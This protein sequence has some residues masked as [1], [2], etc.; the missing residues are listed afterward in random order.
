M[1]RQ[2]NAVDYALTLLRRGRLRLPELC[3]VMARFGASG[4]TDRS[5]VDAID[6]QVLAVLASREARSEFAGTPAEFADE[7][8]TEESWQDL[9]FDE[10]DAFEQATDLGNRDPMER[11]I[12]GSPTTHRPVTRLRTALARFCRDNGLEPTVSPG[13]DADGPG[14]DGPGPVDFALG[15]SIGRGGAGD[16]V[17]AVD[18]DLRRSVAI[19]TLHPHHQTNPLLLRAFF[20]EAI[21]TGGLEHPNIVPVYRL[22]YDDSVGPYYAMKR[23][24][25]ITLGAAL[26]GLR[27][28]ESS[29][30]ARF[31]LDR[32]LQI[33]IEV[34]QGILYAHDR[35]VIHCDLKPNN[36]LVG[37]YGEVMV[38]DWGLA[39]VVG[40]DGALQARSQFWSGTPGFMAPEQV[41]GDVSRY[42]ARTDVWGLGGL[43]YAILCLAR[44]FVGKNKQDTLHRVLNVGLIPPSKRNPSRTVPA[45][46]EQIVMRAMAKSPDDRYPDVATLISEVETHLAGRRRLRQRRELGQQAVARVRKALHG[47]DATETVVDALQSRLANNPGTNREAVADLRRDLSEEREELALAYREAIRI[48]TEALESGAHHP[49]LAAAMGDLY[50]SIF[51]RLYPATVAA[52]RQVRRLATDMLL[53]LGDTALSAVV[54]AGQRLAEGG[55]GAVPLDPNSDDPWLDAVLAYCGP[56]TAEPERLGVT[57]WVGRRL[58]FLRD[59]KLFAQCTGSQ[60][61]PIAAACEY[62]EYQPGEALFEQGDFGDTLIV[63]EHGWVNVVADG[64]VINTVGEAG[65]LG[66]IAVVDGAERTASAVAATEVGAYLLAADRFNAIVA[67]NGA[68]GLSVMQVLTRRIRE[69]AARERALRS[70]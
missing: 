7:V 62:Q 50:W 17:H 56:E 52:N 68:I 55:D 23:L 66:E 6:A 37:H 16:V 12:S 11:R 57:G 59:V 48:G 64:A 53:R 60:L 32:L 21:I 63:V 28:R 70:E 30:E 42:D 69:S 20:E 31:D 13:L 36:I 51:Q 25:G 26:Q 39:Y 24:D 3:E 54:E 65:C 58:A 35:G 34:C 19:K 18:R 4:A 15:G 43:L 22:G 8:L 40:D 47:V 29:L 41:I 61:L 14:L 44:P 1:E 67:E 10:L 9:S 45:E 5:V 49:P 2:Q 33:F 38:V 46:L 27:K